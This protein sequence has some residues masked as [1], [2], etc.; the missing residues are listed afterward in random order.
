[1]STGPGD[2]QD[3]RPQA[4]FDPSTE[5]LDLIVD[6]ITNQGAP[7]MDHLQQLIDKACHQ[8]PNDKPESEPAE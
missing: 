1:M 5:L 6:D 2:I 7:C 4:D 3:H 8:P